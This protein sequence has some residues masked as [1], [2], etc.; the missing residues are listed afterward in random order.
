[1][2][3]KPAAP[4]APR[5]AANIEALTVGRPD[6][7]KP[8]QDFLS[9]HFGLSRRSAKAVI[10][11]RSVWV[12]RK[13]VWIAH[14]VLRSGDVV[15]VPRAV[16]SAAKRQSA[17]SNGLK[18]L[19]GT[20]GLN[21]FKGLNGSKGFNGLKGATK[22]AS[23]DRQLRHIRVLLETKDF[24]VADKP[25]GVLSNGAPGSAE[26]ILREQLNEPNLQAVHRL[27]RDTSGCLLFAR[28]YAA[29]LAAVEVFKTH[30]VRKEYRAIVAGCFPYAHQR[31]DAPL[32]GQPAVSHVLREHSAAD[33]S[34]LKVRIETGR[35]NQI[36]RHLASVRFPI[37]GDRTF[38]LKHA[39]DPRL[40]SVPRQMLHASSLELPDPTVKG[41]TIKVHSP[42]PADFRATLKLFGMGRR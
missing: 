21:G 27:D 31:I 18:G 14:H 10:D 37:V 4:R 19:N 41:A 5:F 22:E 13:C 7:G 23:G 6:A 17:G 3:R 26:T 25:A 34:F 28:S 24:I 35:T 16:V 2:Y 29:Y 20:K 8:L 30:K 38:G 15:E 33:A 11:G 1:M 42:L 12:N 36:R 9:S 40:M 39:R 32:D